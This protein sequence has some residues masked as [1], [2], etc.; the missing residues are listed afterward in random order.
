MIGE[1]KDSKT[2]IYLTPQ[3][4]RQFEYFCKYQTTLEQEHSKWK[5]V[6]E[7]CKKLQYGT[8]QLTI[9]NG[10]P[11]RID[12]AMQSIVIGLVQI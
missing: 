9:Q 3:E 10:L 7:Y 4:I 6:H 8:I 1:T 5:Q 11:H 2:A 12:N